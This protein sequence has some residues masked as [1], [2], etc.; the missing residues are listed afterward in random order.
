MKRLL[1]MLI[2]LAI[3][4]L[5]CNMPGTATVESVTLPTVKADAGAHLT[6][7]TSEDI[8]GMAK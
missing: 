6:V 7:I 1:V 4:S 8:V 2:A 3:L 5:A